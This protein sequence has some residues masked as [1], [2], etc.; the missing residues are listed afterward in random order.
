MAN[1]KTKSQIFSQYLGEASD[2]VTS[3]VEDS[4]A[5]QRMQRRLALSRANSSGKDEAPKFTDIV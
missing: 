4:Q 1:G 3:F 2:A 5:K